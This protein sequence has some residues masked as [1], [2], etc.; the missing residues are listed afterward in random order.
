[1]LIYKQL[2]YKG[3]YMMDEKLYKSLNVFRFFLFLF[4]PVLFHASIYALTAS[5]AA[6]SMDPFRNITSISLTAT[7]QST[8]FDAAGN[9]VSEGAARVVY[10]EIKK[11]SY[12]KIIKNMGNNVYV[13]ERTDE[14][15]T[16]SI[17][18]NTQTSKTTQGI[19]FLYPEP[20]FVFD[21]SGYAA[22]YDVDVTGDTEA[23]LKLICRIK[24]SGGK[25]KMEISAGENGMIKEAV[26]YNPNGKI[27]EKVTVE[28]YQ[29]VGGFNIPKKI[30]RIL[31]SEKNEVV[32]GIQYE[33]GGVQ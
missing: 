7:S 17:N 19:K 2:K 4:I 18:G 9:T 3:G 13:Q 33:V 30:K 20:Q 29:S 23:G 15:E 27:S 21:L 32:T 31:Y 24:G 11:P 28:E 1:M 25:E 22:G 16:V 5:E 6:A 10:Y 8:T 26:I 14:E 12:I